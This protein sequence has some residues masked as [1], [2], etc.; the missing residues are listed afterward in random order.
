MSTKDELKKKLD[1]LS[2]EDLAKLTR[3]TMP[4]IVE[5]YIKHI[6]HPPQQIFLTL[7]QREVMYGGAAGGGKALDIITPLP[8]PSGWTTMGAVKIGDKLIGADGLPTKVLAISGYLQNRPC[9]EIE[10]SDGSK[11]VADEEHLWRVGHSGSRS[12]KEV[13]LTTKELRKTYKHRN[14]NNWYINNSLALELPEVELPINP[15]LFGA[16][17]GDGD[18]RRGYITTHTDD[19]EII[20]QFAN[21][22]WV[23]E[24]TERYHVRIVGF[25]KALKSA[26]IIGTYRKP[27]SK[28]IPNLYLRASKDQRIALLQGLIDTDGHIDSR[29][30]IEIC[31]TNKVLIDDVLELI[32]SLG[33]KATMHESRATINGKDCGARW[34]IKFVAPF[35]V[36]RLTRKAERQQN[37]K[38]R[39]TTIRRYIV[40]IRAVESRTVQCVKVERDGMFLAGEAM[41]PT[42]NSDALLMAA[43]QYV[44]V[45]GYS[46][47]LLR[48]T[49]ADLMLPG[50]IMDRT[51]SW[52]SDT[53]AHPK[54]GGRTW[55]FPSG[56][57]ITFG[58]LQYDKD[59]YRYQSAEFQFVG[60]DELTQFQEETYKYLF[61]RIRRP[62]ISCLNCKTSMKRVQG[63]YVHANVGV[64]CKT[65]MPDPK[66]IAQ[67]PPAK[68]GMTLFDVPLRMRG[69]TNPGGIG[70]A[71]VRDRFVNAETREKDAI[72]VPALLRDNPS[73]D[74]EEYMK[75][76]E[77]LSMLD[78]ERLLNG[79]WDVSVEGIMFQRFWFGH[80]REAPSK[81]K[82]VRYWDMAATKD[83]DWTVGCKLGLTPEKTWIIA[84]IKRARLTAQNVERLILATANEDGQSVQIRM[85]QEGGSSGLAMIDHYSRNV[86]LGYSFKGHRPTGAKEIRAQPV[87]ISAEAGNM[88]ILT[89]PNGGTPSWVGAFLDEVS[90]FPSK[91]VHDDQVDALSGAFNVLAFSLRARIIV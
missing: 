36:A 41:I 42:H 84:D 78:K 23:C 52:L 21:D 8:T 34:R 12:K 31:L 19:Q 30:Q 50:A 61:S 9:Y 46:A 67:Y 15:Y 35:S 79:D 62:S 76:L 80:I 24:R 66:V 85:E 6:P 83:G 74:Q 11:I 55:V 70:H 22:G 5:G 82:W 2:E 10:F 77:H 4:R 54:D 86:L 40:N 75:S 27:I 53:D 39:S 45:P 7:N 65:T 89:T 58:Y 17:L 64:I 63:S 43:L 72:F 16:W 91:G 57:R 26:G 25:S 88:A 37:S 59:K 71:W 87:S 14:R 18:T 51:S 20:D 69:A 33:I 13:L 32:L 73:I 60:F 29:G 38:L 56:A 3:M 48:R 47:L 81:T 44:D 49:W 68:D 28:H 90:M 1:A